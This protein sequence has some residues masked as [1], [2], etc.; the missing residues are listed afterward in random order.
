MKLSQRFDT[1]VKPLFAP[2]TLIRIQRI[3]SAPHLPPNSFHMLQRCKRGRA[4]GEK[5]GGED[6]GVKRLGEREEKKRRRLYQVAVAANLSV[7]AG[8]AG[9][10]GSGHPWVK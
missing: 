8:P 7:E 2:K 3:H 9:F 10:R 1:K 5:A 6:N 4:G